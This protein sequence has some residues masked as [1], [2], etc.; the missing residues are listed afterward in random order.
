MNNLEEII[1]YLRE[2]QSIEDELKAEII[3]TLENTEEFSEEKIAQL[4]DLFDQEIEYLK[5]Q[6]GEIDAELAE[7]FKRREEEEQKAIEELTTLYREFDE[8]CEQEYQKYE[9]EAKEVIQEYDESV[10]GII[11]DQGESAEIDAIREGLNQG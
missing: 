3:A 4:E 5:D 8:V 10:E 2:F 9:A 1:G 6:G 7:L 11:R